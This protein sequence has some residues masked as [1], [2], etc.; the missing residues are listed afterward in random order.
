MLR[1][2]ELRDE[3]GAITI[4]D[5][6]IVLVSAIFIGAVAVPF[7]LG[8]QA[9]MNKRA[10]TLTAKSVAVEIETALIVNKNDTVPAPVA[11]THNSASQ[12]LNIPLTTIRGTEAAQIPFT[13]GSGMALV[14]A[15]P[16]NPSLAGANIINSR[17]SYCV[18]VISFGQ[19]AFHSSA[20][21]A[22]GCP[23]VTAVENST[24]DDSGEAEPEGDVALDE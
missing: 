22:D 21:P 7:M 24:P 18:A 9:D 4:A 14:P 6:L 20:G 3:R 13:L 19:V 8:Q 10:A 16:T 5:V 11:I 23:A 17:E 12:L 2:H 1:F 15:D